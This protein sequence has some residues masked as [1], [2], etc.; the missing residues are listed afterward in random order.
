LLLQPLAAALEQFFGCRKTFQSLPAP[1]ALANISASHWLAWFYFW[2]FRLAIVRSA[3][4]LKTPISSRAGPEEGNAHSTL[5]GV[6]F[7]KFMNRPTP[8]LLPGGYRTDTSLDA[9]FGRTNPN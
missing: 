2:L 6:V 1:S 8:F 3:I 9:L 7:A 5:L 4:M